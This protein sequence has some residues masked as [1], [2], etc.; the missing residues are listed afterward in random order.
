MQ[1]NAEHCIKAIKETLSISYETDLIIDPCA[2]NEGAMFLGHTDGLA[3]LSLFCDPKPLRAEIKEADL[4]STDFQYFDKTIL[5]G[6]WYDAIHVVSCPPSHLIEKF[7]TT[8]CKFA[9]SVSFLSIEKPGKHIFPPNFFL[10]YEEKMMMNKTSY[11][12]QIWVVSTLTHP[13]RLA[14]HPLNEI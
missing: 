7:I 3:W 8:M 6:L 5:A 9:Q 12:F 13:M 10:M 2:E 11:Y 4:L 14:P 1:S